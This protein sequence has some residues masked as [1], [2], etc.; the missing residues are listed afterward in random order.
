LQNS[1]TSTE[2]YFGARRLSPLDRLGSARRVNGSTASYYPFGEDKSTNATVD[3]WKFGTY[4]RDSA[5]G[6]DYAVS[7]YY[8]NA[9]GRMM[10]PDP[11]SSS[12]SNNPQSWNQYTYS[13]G[14]PV[15]NLDPSG[16]DT[17]GSSW[18]VSSSGVISVTVFDCPP[19]SVSLPGGNPGSG[20]S[21]A[22]QAK[23][24]SVPA[25]PPPCNPTRNSTTQNEIGFVSYHWQQAI[26]A[27]DAIQSYLSSTDG[28]TINADTLATAFLDWSY[29]ES[30]GGSVQSLAQNN[31]FGQ[32]QGSWGGLSI[33]CPTNNPAIPSNTK[34][35]CFSQ[36][37]TWVQ[38]L[39]SVLSL[40]P[41]SAA[42]AVNHESY[43]NA[44]EAGLISNPNEGIAAM[45]QSIANQG[46][47]GKSTY[48]ASIAQLNLASVIGCLGLH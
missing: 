33:P 13:Y 11:S 29:W 31:M 47:N 21:P 36:S 26:G 22:Q 38:E 45:L 48:G 23:S 15:N 8:S 24:K 35:A 39:A 32:Q 37:V 7:R 43:L 1:T 44:L 17:C 19:S 6:L 46:W 20:E 4:W 41:N 40:V 3:A 28:V 30:G 18:S 25:P 27:A 5:S 42:A 16:L 10:T 9:Y 12:D 2:T 34:N 14:D